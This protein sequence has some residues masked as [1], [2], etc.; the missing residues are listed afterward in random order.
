MI[1]TFDHFGYGSNMCTG[2]LRRITKSA[3]PRFKAKLVGYKFAFNK[4][5]DD[6]SGKGN[7]VHTGNTTDEVWGV[8]FMISEDER[9]NLTESEGGY[10]PRED[11]SVVSLDG[12][13]HPV[14]LYVARSGRVREN[15]RPFDWYKS[16]VVRGAQQ[17]KLPES[18]IAFLEQFEANVDQDFERVQ[19]QALTAC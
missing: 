19:H 9:E 3:V 4:L 17:H 1:T 12:T 16:F 14:Q 6:T 5:S 10:D 2:K 8:V 7:I 11:L 15:L 13:S 18:Y